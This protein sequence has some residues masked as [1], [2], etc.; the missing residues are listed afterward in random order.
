MREREYLG[1]DSEE[2]KKHREEHVFRHEL[3]HALAEECGVSYGNDEK[4]VDWIA[5]IIP[6]VNE[7][8]NQL[9]EDGVI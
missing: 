8:V 3:V 4:L 6:H 9:K 7:A 5:A 2:T 1:G